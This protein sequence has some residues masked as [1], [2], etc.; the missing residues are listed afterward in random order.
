MES[1]KNSLNKILKKD[2]LIA[3]PFI[4]SLFMNGHK[5][6]SLSMQ[7]ARIKLYNIKIIHDNQQT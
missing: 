3:I 4:L 5:I 2:I 1:D 7:Q 6:Y